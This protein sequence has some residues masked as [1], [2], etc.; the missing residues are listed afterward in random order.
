MDKSTVPTTAPATASRERL[1]S[2]LM[3]FLPLFLFPISHP[4]GWLDLLPDVVFK[5]P[6]VPAGGSDVLE[7]SFVSPA[8]DGLGIYSV[9]L[10]DLFRGQKAR[11][12]CHFVWHVDL[13]STMKS[14]LHAV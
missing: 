3:G 14:A 9:D 2:M 6:A 1:V 8:G 12:W 7:P 4:G 13:L 5:E 11:E 10:T